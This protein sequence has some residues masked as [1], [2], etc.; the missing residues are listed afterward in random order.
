MFLPHVPNLCV[1]VFGAAVC[2]DKTCVQLA[3]G[4]FGTIGAVGAMY[5]GPKQIAIA[6]V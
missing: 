4:T 3:G 1:Y 2:M 5:V 6:N